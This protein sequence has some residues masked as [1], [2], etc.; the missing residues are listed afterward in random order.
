MAKNGTCLSDTVADV[1][2]KIVLKVPFILAVISTGVIC[3]T[4]FIFI[5]I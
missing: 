5:C 4:F 1:P 2:L 3:Q